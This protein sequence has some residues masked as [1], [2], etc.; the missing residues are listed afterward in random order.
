MVGDLSV[1][2]SAV[3]LAPSRTPLMLARAE[4]NWAAVG[5]TSALPLPCMPSMQGTSRCW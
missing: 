1:E 2:A 4:L 5:L 3:A